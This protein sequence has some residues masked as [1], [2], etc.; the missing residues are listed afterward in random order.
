MYQLAPAQDA[1]I[2]DKFSV[3]TVR[4]GGVLVLESELD[5]EQRRLYQVSVEALDRASFGE[6]NTARATILVEV[7]KLWFKIKLV[8]YITN[9]F[10]LFQVNVEKSL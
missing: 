1:D 2:L 6:V 10:Y 8:N 4:N 5:Y 3:S 7:R 9:P